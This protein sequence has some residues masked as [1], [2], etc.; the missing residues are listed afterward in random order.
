LSV[1]SASGSSG[2]RV[3]VPMPCR[4]A[5]ATSSVTLVVVVKV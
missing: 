1:E 2:L 5:L 3:V 4:H